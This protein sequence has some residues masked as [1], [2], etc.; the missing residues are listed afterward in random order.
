MHLGHVKA[1]LYNHMYARK[2]NGKI[3]LRFDDTN[4]D[5]EKKHFEVA[6]AEDINTLGLNCDS[7]TY[8]SSYFPQVD[9]CAYQLIEKGLAY[10]DFSKDEEINKQRITFQPS[11]YR[12]FSIETNKMEFDLLMK[13]EKITGCLRAKINYKSTNDCMRDPVLYRYKQ[14]TVRKCFPTYDFSCP[15]IDKL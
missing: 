1:L 15:I 4:P 14:T 6:I 3:I 12:D 5:K 9:K 11:P 13:G 10:M 7:I 2:Y 8:A